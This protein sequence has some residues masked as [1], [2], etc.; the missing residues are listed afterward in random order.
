MYLAREADATFSVA[1]ALVPIDGNPTLLMQSI[2]DG[3]VERTSSEFL[4][5]NKTELL[6]ASRKK[7]PAKRFTFGSA[8]I[9][10]GGFA[11]VSG[12]HAFLVQVTK[13]KPSEGF[14]AADRKFMGSFKV[15]D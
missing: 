8:K 10:G 14:D 11:A 3:L 2:L 9:W 5:I 12:H 1:H 4:S 13:H 7:L 6:S 15:L